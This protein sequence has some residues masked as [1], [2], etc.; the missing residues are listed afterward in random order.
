MEWNV[1]FM[2]FISVR[3]GDRGWPG[4]LRVKLVVHESF[5]IETT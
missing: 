5:Q 2:L 1:A 4:G 3:V